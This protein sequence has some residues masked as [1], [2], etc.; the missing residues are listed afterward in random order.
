MPSMKRGIPAIAARI[1]RDLFL[2][3]L[4]VHRERL[5]ADVGPDFAPAL[6]EAAVWRGA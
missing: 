4:A 6:Y 1:G 5:T 2:A 3:D